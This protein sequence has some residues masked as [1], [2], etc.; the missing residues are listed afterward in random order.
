MK[1]FSFTILWALFIWAGATL[2]FV[3]FG[4]QVLIEPSSKGFWL[5]LFLLEAGTAVL[6]YILTMLYIR[7]D[8]SSNAAITFAICGTVT[9]LFLDTFSISNHSFLFAGFSNGQVI[10][11]TAWMS[12]AYALYIAIPLLIHYRRRI[13][14]QQKTRRHG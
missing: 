12:F 11:F 2:F 6:L 10:A 3:L 13:L 14:K 1:K 9:G 5:V 8:Q 4:Q 7:F